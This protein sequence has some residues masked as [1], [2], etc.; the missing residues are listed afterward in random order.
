MLPLSRNTLPAEYSRTQVWDV[1]YRLVFPLKQLVEGFL[2]EVAA[3]TA[4]DTDYEIPVAVDFCPVDASAGNAT[5][6]LPD[7]SQCVGKRFTVKKIDT[8]VYTVTV[9]VK[10]G[11]TIDNSTTQVITAAYTSLCFMSDGAEYWIV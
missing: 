11:E 8:S 6:V 2:F 4:T 3:N 10:T 5:R 9:S 1:I 7:P